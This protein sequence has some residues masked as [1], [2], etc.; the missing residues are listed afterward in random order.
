MDPRPGP[1][2]ELWS[3]REDVHVE[4][5]AGGSLIV[6][7]RW[8]EVLLPSAGAVEHEALRRMSLGPILLENVVSEPDARDSLLTGLLERL[9]HLIVRSFGLEP[10]QLLLSVVPLTRQAG[11]RPVPL[12]HDLPVR[13]S[14]FTMLR[15]DGNDYLMESPLSLHRVVL[16]RAEAFWALSSLARPVTPARAQA[17]LPTPGSPLER[18]F[19]QLLSTLVAAGMA[20]QAETADPLVFGEDRDSALA[21]WSPIDLMFHTRATIGRHDHDFGAT[22]PLG[23]R[24]FVEPVVKQPASRPGIA[25]Y[26]PLWADL[27]ANDPPLTATVEGTDR[28]QGACPPTV[29]ELGEL[30]YRAIRVRSLVGD[31]AVPAAT[32]ER[33]YQSLGDRYELEIY[34]T[35]GACSGLPRGCYHYDPAGHL[36]EP[37][38]VSEA[39]V[40]EL[41]GNGGLA[42][43]L[44]DPPPVLLTVT[45]RFGRIHWRYEGPGYALIHKNVGSV[46]Q[47][48]GMVS[49]AMGLPECSHH[50]SDIEAASRIFG[51][52]WRVESSV[53]E[54][55]IGSRPKPEASRVRTPVNDA[56]WSDLAGSLLSRKNSVRSSVQYDAGPIR[57]PK[58][59]RS[60]H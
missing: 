55:I 30:L 34:V 54:F 29:E 11:L 15:G 39:D 27:V 58:V 19:P 50:C 46:L 52:D 26:R 49:T 51:T 37:L 23:E 48:L 1:P 60:R 33:P 59:G 9:D 18:L 13:M 44:P 38:E 21:L 2:A 16:H 24:S 47:L 12:D 22:Y 32:S 5:A 20:V 45:A 57:S 25:L 7:S 36:L 40:S 4:T 28:P 10:D 43:G 42:A 53:G 56:A 3:L 8:G 31:P 41:L 14:R 6:H 35:A 17:A